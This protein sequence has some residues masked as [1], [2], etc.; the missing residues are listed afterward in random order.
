MLPNIGFASP[1]SRPTGNG[2]PAAAHVSPLD[3]ADRPEHAADAWAT[4]FSGVAE[5]E[6]VTPAHM[7]AFVEQLPV[8]VLLVDR[9][10]RVVYTNKAARALRVE[11]AA[12]S[13]PETQ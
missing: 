2:T 5:A 9:D 1:S 3:R 12:D 8:G 11:R 4:P 6:L 13:V 10:G 7:N